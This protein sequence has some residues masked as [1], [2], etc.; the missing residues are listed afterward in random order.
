[1]KPV[2]MDRDHQTARTRAGVRVNPTHWSSVTVHAFWRWTS[3]AVLLT[4][5]GI[6]VDLREG[7]AH[8]TDLISC[9]GCGEASWRHLRGES[10]Q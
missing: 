5:C 7:G 3:D 10:A 1:M 6:E 8:T 4:W 2:F 9:L